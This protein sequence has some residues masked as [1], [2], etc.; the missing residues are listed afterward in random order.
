MD[1]F[2]ISYFCYTHLYYFINTKTFYLEFLD[3][4]YYE[5]RQMLFSHSIHIIYIL[6]MEY[7]HYENTNA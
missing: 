1:V 6:H 5:K 3:F 7:I 4:H 2:S